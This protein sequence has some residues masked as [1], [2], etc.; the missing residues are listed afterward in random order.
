MDGWMD[1]PRSATVGQERNAWIPREVK[2]EGEI[3]HRDRQADKI[4][5]RGLLLR[6]EW[7][8][9]PFCRWNNRGELFCPAS[10]SRSP[11]QHSMAAV[12]I[13]SGRG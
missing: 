1:P 9:L 2:R 8:R 4:M 3:G 13:G 6:S 12:M 7:V 11:L 10:E 5:A